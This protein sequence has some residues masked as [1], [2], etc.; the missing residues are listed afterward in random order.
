MPSDVSDHST[1]C[2][3]RRAAQVRQCLVERCRHLVVAIGRQDEQRTCADVLRDELEEKQRALV[4]PVHV[5]ED[6]QNRL[7][8]VPRDERAPGR[9]RRHENEQI[10]RPAGRTL[11]VELLRAVRAGRG[12]STGRAAQQRA[13]TLRLASV[14]CRRASA[15]GQ[16][17]GD[18]SRSPERPQRTRTFRLAALAANSWASVV[19]PIPG[20][21]ATSTTW[22]RPRSASPSAPPSFDSSSSRLRR[23]RRPGAWFFLKRRDYEALRSWRTGFRTCA[24]GSS[25]SRRS[26]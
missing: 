21:P 4:G 20:S 13:P 5:L 14:N 12:R 19:F 25:C 17:G 18:P 11:P 1:R 16:Y 10:R 2:A 24:E 26:P 3:V 23:R 15:H 22:P 9:R 6:E 8:A 7:C